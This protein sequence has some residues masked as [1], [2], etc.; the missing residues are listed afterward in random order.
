MSPNS[1]GA[2]QPFELILVLTLIESVCRDEHSMNLASDLLRLAIPYSDI[3]TTES[4]KPAD[5]AMG[6]GATD[7][8]L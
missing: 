8:V 6:S 1:N 7:R 2:S 5:P 3:S 4:A